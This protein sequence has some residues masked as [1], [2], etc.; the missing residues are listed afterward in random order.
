MPASFKMDDTTES[1]N[2]LG[3]AGEEIACSLLLQKGHTILHRRYQ[4]TSGEIDIISTIEN[5]LV[6]T[7]V[8]TRANRTKGLESVRVS[9]Q[10]RI[11]KTALYFMQDY[12]E[13]SHCNVRFDVVICVRGQKPYHLENA[14]IS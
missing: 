12:P 9:Q 13:Y 1:K 7:E 4:K 2:L 6:F 14:W 11:E 10:K 3:I 5:T 8:K